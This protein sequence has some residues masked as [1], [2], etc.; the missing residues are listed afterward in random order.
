MRQL[1]KA[2]GRRATPQS[3]TQLCTQVERTYQVDIVAVPALHRRKEGVAAVQLWEARGVWVVSRAA[4]VGRPKGGVVGWCT[5]WLHKY[6]AGAVACRKSWRS[7]H[8]VRARRVAARDR[9]NNGLHNR[10]GC[11]TAWAAQGCGQQALQRW[12]RGACALLGVEVCVAWSGAWSAGRGR[13]ASPVR[14]HINTERQGRPAP[15]QLLK[16]DVQGRC[17]SIIIMQM[18]PSTPEISRVCEPLG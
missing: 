9:A 15:H 7:C 17:S 14:R 4:Q 5:G 6:R 10:K 3:V 16:Y 1:L 12:Q 2:S 18:W 8:A 11:R 13:Q